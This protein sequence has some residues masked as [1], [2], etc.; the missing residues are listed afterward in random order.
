[1]EDDQAQRP[2]RPEP[3]HRE[4]VIKGVSSSTMRMLEN[5]LNEEAQKEKFRT[6]GDVFSLKISGLL[7]RELG[8]EVV[9]ERN[10]K[11]QDEQASLRR[12]FIKYCDKTGYDPDVDT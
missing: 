11:Y 6:P 4:W 7:Y 8:V 5:W 3:M 2:K 12:A 10:K 1:M 9:T